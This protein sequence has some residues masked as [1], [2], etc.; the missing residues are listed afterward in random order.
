MISYIILYIRKDRS[1]KERKERSINRLYYTKIVK[2]LYINHIDKRCNN[3]LM[4]TLI[5]S[6]LPSFISVIS[7]I[8]F[9]LRYYAFVCLIVCF[10]E[11]IFTIVFLIMIILLVGVLLY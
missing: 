2:N 6:L 4:I 1:K 7:Q 11:F 9:I 8:S 3:D 5:N 10:H